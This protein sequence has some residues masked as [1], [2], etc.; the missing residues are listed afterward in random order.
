MQRNL[1]ITE[2]SRNETKCLP[3]LLIHCL[4]FSFQTSCPPL[5]SLPC[6]C[7]IL[8]DRPLRV[9][10]CD[11]QRAKPGAKGILS[12]HRLSVSD[13][14]EH[15]RVTLLTEG[16]LITTLS[17][18]RWPLI[19]RARRQPRN[20]RPCLGTSSF[21]SVG[22]SHARGL[23]VKCE[24]AERVRCVMSERPGPQREQF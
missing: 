21:F 18:C 5:K 9:C 16:T 2:K 3:S 7:W 17:S 10:V 15:L 24:L 11:C 22:P 14:P 23:F 12:D 4:S 20:E 1:C 19:T 6:I 13:T 8:E